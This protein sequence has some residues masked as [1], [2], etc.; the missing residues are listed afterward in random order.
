MVVTLC[1][2]ALVLGACGTKAQPPK[3]V[4]PSPTISV[5]ILPTPSASGGYG[6]GFPPDPNEENRRNYIAELNKIDPDI[7]H[8]KEETAVSRGQNQCSSIKLFPGNEAKWL[9]LTLQRFTSPKHPD[10]FGKTK[11]AKI[12]VVVRK[13]ICPTY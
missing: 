13:Y 11:A 8:G 6:I 5:S 3:T 7:V 10:G 9:E 12:L 2:A 1:I 4:A